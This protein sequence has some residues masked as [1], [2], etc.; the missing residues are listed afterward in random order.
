MCSR[1]LVITFI[2]LVLFVFYSE[3]I[4]HDNFVFQNPNIV[5]YKWVNETEILGGSLPANPVND[6]R[7][8]NAVTLKSTFCL[9]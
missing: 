4:C 9:P 8:A 3:N 5:Y 1:S 7:I 6:R 2:K